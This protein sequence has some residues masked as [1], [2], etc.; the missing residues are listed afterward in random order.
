VNTT[1]L[2]ASIPESDLDLD[3]AG[4]ADIA[5]F[6]AP[7]GGGL[8]STLTLPID[9]PPSISLSS[10]TLA[11]GAAVTMT[12]INGFGGS[13]DWLSFAA[14]TAPYTSNISWRYV[15][16]GLSTQTWTVNVPT[17]PGDYEFRLFVNNGYTLKAVSPTITVAVPPNP[18]PVATALSPSHI[19]AGSGPF[20][21]SVTG[22]D[23]KPSSVVRWNGSDRPTTYVSATQLN[24]AIGSA[25]VAAIGAASVSVFSPTPGGGT[26]GTLT[27]NVDPPPSLSVSTLS[28]PGGSPATVTLIN[29]LGG[30]TDWLALAA[31]TA[32]NT[33]Y[34]TWTYVGA[35][36]TSRTWTVN[37]P[38]TVG[39]YEFRLFKSGYTRVA[40]SPT[41]AVT[42][43]GPIATS[44]SPSSGAVGGPAF[45]LT[46][47]GSNLLAS[48]VVRWNGD[49]RPTMFVSSSQIR[50]AIPASDIAAVGTAQVT[51]FTPSSGGSLTAPLTFSISQ[52]PVLTVS[53]TNA[54]GGS[55]VTV[56]LANGFGGSN[57]WLALASTSAPNTS[58]LQ[59]VYVGGGVTSRTWTVNMPSTAG[60]YEFRLFVNGYTRVATSPPITVTP[61]P[62]ASLSV[63]STLVTGGSPVTVTVT[64]SPGGSTDWIAFAATGAPNTNYL[65]WV[66]VGAGVTTRTWTVTTPTAAGTYEFRLFLNNAY[67]R[68]ATSPPVTVTP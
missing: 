28:A 2:R 29:G 14:K 20:T 48:S 1:T 16:T 59:W 10:A 13:M 27:F 32:P 26:S 7:P 66:Y 34:L 49:D 60:T 17:T 47:N 45:T 3:A 50:A 54:T 39:S 65:Q 51:V 62:P 56:T 5:V 57:D 22:S 38:A 25:D 67:I 6:T 64:N 58:Y 36:I 9:P 35:G 31:T 8:S 12:L 41:I 63:D 68:A 53:A 43:P 40:T 61:A 42:P 55:P 4:T 24:A 23:F 44:L 15:G 11:P 46:V 19:A 33:S 52:L 18:V 21:L 37:L 30:A